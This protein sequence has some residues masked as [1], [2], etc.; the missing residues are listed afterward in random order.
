MSVLVFS[1][2][3]KFYPELCIALV[4]IFSLQNQSFQV[5]PKQLLELDNDVIIYLLELDNDVIIYLLTLV[6]QE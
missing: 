3:S 6:E 5:G 2:N 1:R 4:L